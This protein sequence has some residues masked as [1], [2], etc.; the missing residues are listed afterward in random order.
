M[1]LRSRCFTLEYY[2]G[3]VLTEVEARRRRKHITCY[4]LIICSLWASNLGVRQIKSETNGF[5][6]RTEIHRVIHDLRGGVNLTEAAWLLITIWMLNQ[7]SMGFQPVRQAPP[8]PHHQLFGGT[9]K[10]PPKNDFSK[11]NQAGASLQM[12]RPS[13]MPH[14]DFTALTKEEKRNLPDHRDGFIDVEG[15]PKLTVRYGQVNFKVPK[16]GHIHS[17]S[18]NANGKTPKTEKNTLALRDSLV[19]MPE[20]EGI[21]WFDNGGYQKGTERGYASINVYHKKERVIAI[22]KKQ[23]NRE[24]IFSTTCKVTPVEE[25]YLYQSDGNYVTEAVLSNQNGLT[26]INS[27]TNMNNNDL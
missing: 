14:Q 23:E 26:V 9:S 15:H 4:T 25:N 2:P 16:H 7:Q 21:R 20:R 22:Y 13:A 3:E 18:V 27:I 17:L 5:Q 10:L 8:P 1:K 12:E 24:Y 6:T 19:K 11:S